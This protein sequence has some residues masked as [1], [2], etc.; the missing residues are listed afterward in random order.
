MI[1]I[2]KLEA[3]RRQDLRLADGYVSTAKYQVSRTATTDTIRFTLEREALDDPYEKRWPQ[4]E[5]D[6]THCSE[7]VKQGLSLAAYDGDQLVGIAISEKL[8]WNRS[9]WIREF[10]IAESHRRRGLGGLLMDRVSQVAKAEGVKVLVCETQNTNVPAIDFY[11]SIGFEV[12]GIDLS[13]YTHSYIGEQEVAVF[14][15]RK[16]E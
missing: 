14:M 15:K 2:R 6:F 9:L 7:I 12:D 4:I 11:H 16:V 5:E 3:L 10:G 1:E 13:Y 8:E